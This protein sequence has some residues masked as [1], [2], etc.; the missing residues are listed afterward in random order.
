[1]ATATQIAT[2]ALKRLAVVAP[3]ETPSA[4]DTQHAEEVLDELIASW[5]GSWRSSDVL[6]LDARFEGGVIAILAERLAEDYGRQ[7]TPILARDAEQ[8]RQLMDA[9]FIA[10]PV[11][12]F[13]DG[14]T[15][16][17]HFSGATYILGEEPADYSPWAAGTA[18]SVRDIVTASGLV[19]EC[20]TAGT[21]G[22]TAPSAAETAVADGSVVWCFRRVA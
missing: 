10:V 19:Y 3:D 17:G 8:G 15:A 9:A 1:M 22:S 2:R 4:L 21:S 16:T 20:T 7:I 6:P 14:L 18:Y 11:Q 5:E 12:R 13:D